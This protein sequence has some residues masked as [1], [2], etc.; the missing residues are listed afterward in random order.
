MLIE[1]PSPTRAAVRTISGRTAITSTGWWWRE[2]IHLEAAEGVARVL[3]VH[4]VASERAP[5]RVHQLLGRASRVRELLAELR[6][7]GGIAGADLDADPSG[8]ELRQRGELHRDQARVA[9]GGGDP[10]H[11]DLEPLGL[12]E[13]EGAR[14]DGVV[15]A[16][17]FGRPDAVE[18]EPLGRA[19]GRK[20]RVDRGNAHEGEAEPHE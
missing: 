19:H 9:T 3:D 12:P 10:D 18:P 17:V 6:D 8:A 14:D 4:L 5:Q 7:E 1:R 11:G 15:K 13:V 16:D 2:R 20:R